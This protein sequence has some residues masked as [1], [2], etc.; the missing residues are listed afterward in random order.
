MILI[1]KTSAVETVAERVPALSER[2]APCAAAIRVCQHF[3]ILGT[4]LL[5]GKRLVSTVDFRRTFN[6]IRL[7]A[8]IGMVF[9]HQFAV[10][11]FNGV[12]VRIFGDTQYFVIIFF[13]HKF[14]FSWL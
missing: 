8:H 5:V 7:F 2:I 3:I 9:A 11:F 12:L 10:G 6:G 14:S 1:T 13:C 4:F